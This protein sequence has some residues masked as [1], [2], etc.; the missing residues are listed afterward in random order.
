[1]TVR[2]GA[3]RS[4]YRGP[5]DCGFTGLGSCFGGPGSG[6]HDAQPGA[7]QRRVYLRWQRAQ[8]KDGVTLSYSGGNFMNQKLREFRFIAS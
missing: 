8:G 7:P 5:D 2:I 6:P 3:G 1:M 4:S